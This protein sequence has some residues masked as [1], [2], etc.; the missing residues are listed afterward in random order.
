MPANSVTPVPS[1]SPTVRDTVVN[2]CIAGAKSRGA[3][4]AVRP[5]ERLPA[6]AWVRVLLVDPRARV[7]YFDQV[8]AVFGDIPLPRAPWA[9]SAEAS[10]PPARLREMAQT[11]PDAFTAEELADLL[12][13]VNA[14]VA[15]ATLVEELMPDWWLD[16]LDADGAR[17]V[18][19]VAVEFGEKEMVP[20]VVEP[21]RDDDVTAEELEALL[22][23]ARQ[24]GS[25]AP[26]SDY[27]G[28]T[29]WALALPPAVSRRIAAVAYGDPAESF[30]LRLHRVRD[31]RAEVEISPAP[32][33]SDVTLLATF[34]RTGDARTF[35]LR[36]PP[37]AKAPNAD[38][39]DFRPTTRSSAC[40]S[41]PSAAY[42]TPAN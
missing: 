20:E 29:S 10:S 12:L 7:G 3:R 27:D 2:L 34:A 21:A 24:M 28:P 23:T 8:Y 36:V 1:A 40:D 39:R 9:Q 11:G 38:P 15:I 19:M 25:S 42:H 14:L 35:V 41:L 17:Y 16:A 18:T 13:D 26:E 31:G 6:A 32:R 37:E 30:T 22:S 5:E 4:L 33:K